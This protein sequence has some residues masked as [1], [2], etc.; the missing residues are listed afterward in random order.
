MYP[1]QLSDGSQ[2][3]KTPTTFNFILDH[4]VFD[5][6]LKLLLLHEIERIEISFRAIISNIYALKYGS[7]WYLDSKF[8]N[9]NIRHEHLIKE[10][11]KYCSETSDLFIKNYNLKYTDPN[12][13]RFG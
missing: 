7:H 5:K 10:I 6:K 4:Y 9:D 1:F 13:Q 11:K 2:K 12:Y 3:F 8:F